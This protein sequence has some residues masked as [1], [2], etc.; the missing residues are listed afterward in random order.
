[1]T[2]VFVIAT[3]PTTLAQGA[4]ALGSVTAVNLGSGPVPGADKT[5][6]VNAAGL[7]EG[8]AKPIAELLSARGAEVVLFDTDVQSRLLAGKIAS[9]LGTAARNAAEIKLPNIGRM[10]YGGLA[11]ATESVA[12]VAV[13]VVGPGVLPPLEGGSDA[14]ENIALTPDDAGL[15]LVSTQPKGG[16]SV[17]LSAAK[18]VV[19]VGR[20]FAAQDDLDLAR[21]LAAKLGAELACSRPIAEGVN[22]MPTE[23]YIGVSG[24]TLRP[25]LYLAVGISGQIQHMVGVNK[26]KA[27]VAINKDKN[28]PVFKQADFGIVGDLYQVLPALIAAL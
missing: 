21:Q 8:Y 28:A 25:E 16:E 2:E 9:Y 14:V 11:V 7:V 5:L 6:A 13:L 18:R 1:M 24:A 12:G 4:R 23:R 15:K 3:G 19:G 20:G 22:W 26:A 17:N 27:I 10:V